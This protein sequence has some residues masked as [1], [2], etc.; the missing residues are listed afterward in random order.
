M[1]LDDAKAKIEAFFNAYN[2]I[3]PNNDEIMKK[4]TIGKAYELYCLSRLIEILNKNYGYDILFKGN[5]IKFKAK[6]SDINTSYPYFEVRSGS[7][8][9]FH[10]YT[11]TYVSSLGSC[12]SGISDL[13]EKNEADILIVEDDVTG[14]P[15]P[16]DVVL[17]LECKVR[18]IFVKANVREILGMRRELSYFSKNDRS[19]LSF[20]SPSN[21]I[22]LVPANPESEYWFAYPLKNGDDYKQSPAV[23][24]IEFY[25]WAP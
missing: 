17:I 16:S 2:A 18:S 4:I 13:S 19:K 24:G 11:D 7:R 20:F 1:K 22:K 6:G 25:N 12:I 3:F 14:R 5:T 8:L 21:F 15:K 9:L 23:F 10:I